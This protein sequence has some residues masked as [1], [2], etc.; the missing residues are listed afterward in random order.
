MQR[1]ERFEY[2]P[3]TSERFDYLICAIHAGVEHGTADVA[4]AIHAAN[5]DTTGLFIDWNPTHV[6]STVYFHPVFDTVVRHY[7]SVISIHGM[8]GYGHQVFVGGRDHAVVSSLRQQLGAH[9][10]PPAHLAGTHPLN[11]ANRGYSGAGVQI[12]IDVIRLR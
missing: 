6:T 2:K 12:E 8:N 1:R 10:A 9:K 11:V 3:P 5:P 4:R 7:N